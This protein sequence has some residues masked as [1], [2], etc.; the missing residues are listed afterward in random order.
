MKLYTTPHGVDE[1]RVVAGRQVRELYPH[2]QSALQDFPNLQGL[3]A[4]PRFERD[5]VETHWHTQGREHEGPLTDQSPDVQDAAK[6]SIRVAIGQIKALVD[7]NRRTGTSYG[8]DTAD[9]LDASLL[10]PDD[11]SIHIVDGKPVIASWGRS[12][13]G[14]SV[15]NTLLYDISGYPDVE[16]DSP[17][18]TEDP[19]A[20]PADPTPG[21]VQEDGEDHQIRVWPAATGPWL[22]PVLWSLSALVFAMLLWLYLAHCAFLKLGSNTWLGNYCTAPQNATDPTI[23]AL[24]ERLRQ[25]E[26]EYDRRDAVCTAPEGDIPFDVP[27][28][29]PVDPPGGVLPLDPPGPL[30]T[31]DP[32]GTTEEPLPQEPVTDSEVR[33]EEQGGALGSINIILTWNNTDD[34]DLHVTCPNGER[35]YHGNKTACGG[36]LD[37]DDNFIGDRTETPAENIVFAQTPGDGRYS[38]RVRRSRDDEPFEAG[39]PFQLD[40]IG[41]RNGERFTIETLQGEAGRDMQEFLVLE[42]PYVE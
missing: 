41:T 11:R 12:R 18:G 21:T 1:E 4:E 27:P 14:E 9:I 7:E 38:I 3:F 13:I 33:I 32:L 23:I 26:R 40:V 5:E 34:L 29:G 37:L 19:T 36:T 24:E 30:D 25:L 10:I 6:S 31:T 22:V 17:I 20:H 8:Q 16:E 39:T 35:I 28:P 42:I 2:L 15:K